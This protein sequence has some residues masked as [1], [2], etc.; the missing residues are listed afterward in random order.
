ME[1]CLYLK[2]NFGSSSVYF[3]VEP[4]LLGD[5]FEATEVNVGMQ[6]WRGQAA[7]G[8]RLMTSRDLEDL[9]GEGYFEVSETEFQRATGQF[10]RAIA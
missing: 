9:F 5:L 2:R 7:Q 10:Q 4:K 8:T 3:Y 1:N 6:S